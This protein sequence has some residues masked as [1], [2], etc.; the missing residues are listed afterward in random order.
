MDTQE[1]VAAYKLAVKRIRAELARLDLTDMSRKVTEAALVEVARILRELDAES[2]AWV[3]AAI[4]EAAAAGVAGTLTAL[5]AAPTVKTFSRVNSAMVTSMVADTQADLLAVTQNID[6]RVRA[7]IR[8]AA[9]TSMRENMAA[10]INGR[11]TISRDILTKMRADLGKAVETGII[12]AGGRRWKPEDYVDMV[13]RT[14]TTTASRE[15]MV[16][17]ALG[18]GVGYFR[19]SSHGAKDGCGKW[20]GRILKASSDIDGDFPTIAESR[21]NRGLF[22]PNCKHVLTPVRNPEKKTKEGEK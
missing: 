5:G 20:E 18:R 2:A 11:R 6:R 15:A 12:D 22:H 1:L 19:V 21:E 9:A 14:K 8:N 4:P 7:G 3:A 10:G 16:N 17:E 13:V